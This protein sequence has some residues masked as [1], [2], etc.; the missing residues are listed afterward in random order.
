VPSHWGRA[1]EYRKHKTLSENII[2]SMCLGSDLGVERR[3]RA[4]V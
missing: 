3:D 1:S 4:L 2:P